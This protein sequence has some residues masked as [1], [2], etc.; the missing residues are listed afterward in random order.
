[1]IKGIV[2]QTT[3]GAYDGNELI[4]CYAMKIEVCSTKVVPILWDA[5]YTML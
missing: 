4:V 1:M 5:F 2:E 3:F